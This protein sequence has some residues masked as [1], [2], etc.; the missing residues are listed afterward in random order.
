MGYKLAVSLYYLLTSFFT[1]MERYDPFYVVFVIMAQLRMVTILTSFPVQREHNICQG[2]IEEK[3]SDE[4]VSLIRRFGDTYF[5]NNRNNQASA[6]SEEIGDIWQDKGWHRCQCIGKTC[7]VGA[8]ISWIFL[9]ISLNGYLF[10][11]PRNSSDLSKVL[12]QLITLV[13]CIL[14]RHRDILFDI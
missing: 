11:I 1:F 9:V 13:S 3:K 12:F 5:E 14:A 8:D 6:K 7:K 2:P 4:R 10:W